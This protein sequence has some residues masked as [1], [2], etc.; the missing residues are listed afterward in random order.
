MADNKALQ[1][2]AKAQQDEFY[3]SMEDIA[4]ELGHYWEHF[5]GRKILCNCDDPYESKFFRY[6]AINFNV[7]KLAKLT[8]TCYAGSP[9]AHRQ[10]SLGFDPPE[11][12]PS[13]RKPYCAEITDLQDYNHD[14][15]AD[16]ADIEYMLTYNVGAKVRVL[17]GDGDF[18]SSE[19]L[20]LLR[21]ADVVVTNPPHSLLREYIALLVKHNKKFLIIG[22][23]NAVTYKEVFPLFMQNKMW[24]GISIHSGDRKFYVPDT[25]P[26]EAAGCGIDKNGRRFIRVKGVRWFTNLDVK[27]RR[28]FMTLWRSYEQNPEQYPHYDNYNA[29]EVSRTDMIPADYDGV[30]GVPITFLDKYNPEQ[31]EILG[32]TQRDSPLKTKIYKREDAPNFGDLNARATIRDESGKLHSTYVRLLI[33]KIAERVK[34]Y[35]IIHHGAEDSKV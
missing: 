22:N 24:M 3:T 17:E 4:E 5:E 6:F 33:R 13:Q 7:L 20:E 10:L 15:A 19:C 11:T 21:D 1:R 8:A 2:A 34:V 35:S 25:Y 29:I 28:D 14:T 30:M 31:F 18:R 23:I 12:P 27:E 16:Y 9:I 32:I 26:L